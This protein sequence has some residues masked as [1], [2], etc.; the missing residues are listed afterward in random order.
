VF[1]SNFDQ[2]PSLL[3]ATIANIY[4]NSSAGQGKRLNTFNVLCETFGF[5]IPIYT[6]LLEKRAFHVG[7]TIEELGISGNPSFQFN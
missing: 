6:Y 3:S 1:I 4:R 2:H 5:G 7:V